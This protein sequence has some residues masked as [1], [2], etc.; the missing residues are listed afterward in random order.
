VARD[1]AREYEDFVI[2]NRVA[3]HSDHPGYKQEWKP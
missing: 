3:V 2:P 1:Q